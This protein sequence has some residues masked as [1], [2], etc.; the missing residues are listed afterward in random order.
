MDYDWEDPNEVRELNV[1]DLACGTG[2]LLKSSLG[3]VL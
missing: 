2:T 1:T 3:A